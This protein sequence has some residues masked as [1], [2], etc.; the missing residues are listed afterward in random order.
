MNSLFGSDFLTRQESFSVRISNYCVLAVK[1][2]CGVP[3][4]S[5]N[6]KARRT[7][8]SSV[9]A[10]SRDVKI[11]ASCSNFA[12]VRWRRRVRLNIWQPSVRTRQS[13]YEHTLSRAIHAFVNWISKTNCSSA[14]RAA[15]NNSWDCLPF[16]LLAASSRVDA[17]SEIGSKD[18]VRFFLIARRDYFLPEKVLTPFTPK[19]RP[20]TPL[21]TAIHLL[22]SDIIQPACIS[23]SMFK[24]V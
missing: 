20:H 16:F 23:E 13:N 11:E 9:E 14:R 8:F 3:R 22:S 2:F 17:S 21:R 19:S 24:D 4:I 1:K 6:D 10:F 12:N 18:S 15:I 5:L 7:N